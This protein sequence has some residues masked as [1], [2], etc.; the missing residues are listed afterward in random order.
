VNAL[1][2]DRSWAATLLKL[3][4]GWLSHGLLWLLIRL[5]RVDVAAFWV[6]RNVLWPFILGQ[7]WRPRWYIIVGCWCC[8]CTN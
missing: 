8:S 7:F 4:Q 3:L 1:S 5:L 2:L 6:W